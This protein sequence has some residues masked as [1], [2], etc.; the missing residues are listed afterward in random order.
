MKIDISVIIPIF[1]GEKF[2]ERCLN[3]LIDAYNNVDNFTIEVILVDDGSTDYSKNIINKFIKQYDWIKYFY[4]ENQGPSAA[5][6][7]GLNLANGI[8]ISFV[9]CDDKVKPNFFKT[10]QRVIIDKPDLVVFGYERILSDMRFDFFSPKERIEIGGEKRLTKITDDKELFWYPWSKIYQT[11]LVKNIYFDSRMRLGEDTIFNLRAVKKANMIKRVPDIL[12]SYYENLGSLSSPSYKKG[13]LENMEYHF[14]NRLKEHEYLDNIVKSDI[15][16]YYLGHILSWLINNMVYLPEGERKNELKR[17]TES[18][19]FKTCIK[20]KWN[21]R[22]KGQYLILLLL[23][24]RM[25]NLLNILLNIKYSN[26]K[27]KL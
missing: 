23:K 3:G 18:N 21:V 20:W 15:S 24:L 11:E 7:Y 17:I 6:N 25:F 27:V 1:N 9:D 10:L 14:E 19:F 2:I 12:Y 13:L 8:Y 22:S 26:K 4:Q 16:K 5:R